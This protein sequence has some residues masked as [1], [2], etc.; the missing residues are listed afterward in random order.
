[1][2]NLCTSA[3]REYGNAKATRKVQ[4]KQKNWIQSK[5]IFRDNQKFTLS[6]ALIQHGRTRKHTQSHSSCTYPIEAH[7]GVVEDG[8]DEIE[9]NDGRH[10]DENVEYN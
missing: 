1:M 10:Q 5:N 7:V 8:D 9:E 3:G 2:I 4:K 6:S